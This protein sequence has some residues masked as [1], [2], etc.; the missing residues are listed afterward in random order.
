MQRCD[1]FVPPLRPGVDPVRRA[2]EGCARGPAAIAFSIAALIAL[3]VICTNGLG[4][5]GIIVVRKGWFAAAAAA[6]AAACAA[7]AMLDSGGAAWE[8]LLLTVATAAERSTAPPI[9]R[10]FCLSLYCEF[11]DASESTSYF[12]F[13]LAKVAKVDSIEL[14]A[15]QPGHTPAAAPSAVCTPYMPPI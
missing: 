14:C 3:G 13:G 9:T 10:L 4:G 11:T 15:L 8:A 2:R 7:S 12:A 6:A 1:T 5:T